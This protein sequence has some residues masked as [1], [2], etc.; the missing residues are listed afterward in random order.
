MTDQRITSQSD[1]DRISVELSSRRTGMSFQRTRMS[2][3]RTLMSVIRTSLSLIGF[4]FTIFQFFEKL[5]EAGTLTHAGAPRHFGISLVALGILML[6]GGIG[7][8]LQF[9]YGL[10]EERKAMTAA[11]LIHGESCFPPSLTLITAV[12]LLVIG[13]AAIV[14]MVFRIGPFD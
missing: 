12:I 4:G 7:Y 1:S 6:I 8:H 10:R 9:M 13:I 2:A 3:D 5:K 11:G 14:S